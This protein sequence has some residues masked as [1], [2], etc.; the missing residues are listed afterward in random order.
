MPR[1][2]VRDPIYRGRRFPADLIEQCVRWYITYRLSYRDL[3]AMVAERG[4][5]VS[6]TTIMRWVLRYMPEYERRWS[7]YAIPTADSWRVDETEIVVRGVPHWLYRAVD[8]LV[9]SVHSLF[10]TT[11]TIDAAQA[12]FQ[13]ATA[14]GD[15]RWPARINVDGYAATQLSLRQ[16]A[17]ADERWRPVQVRQNRYLNNL[18]EQDHRAI[19]QR[20]R[21]MLG[22]KSVATAA[23]TLAGVELAHRIRKRQFTVVA[24]AA[25]KVGSLREAWDAALA[26]TPAAG[27]ESEALPPM[28]RNSAD[29]SF[30]SRYRVRRDVRP[31]R[32][33]FKVPIAPGLFLVV[34]PNGQRSWRHVYR[35]GGRTRYLNLGSYP[36]LSIGRARDVH[37]A[38]RGFL[39][40]GLDPAAHRPQLYAVRRRSA[41]SRSAPC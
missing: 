22:L 40:R 8:R 15:V 11:R 39:A 37:N 29:H 31:R 32:F 34:K 23:I 18:V 9:K 7:R 19:K 27:H 28:H 20:Y 25:G 30:P 16:L 5:R 3:A 2:A 38:A 17:R 12:F 26:R 6:H 35:F 36:Y 21:A 33:A 14:R 41:R 13:S 24:G 4:V 10:S 1:A